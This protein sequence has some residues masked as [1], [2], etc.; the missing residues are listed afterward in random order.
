[1]NRVFA[2]TLMAYLLAIPFWSHAFVPPVET[3]HLSKADKARLEAVTCRA[4]HVVSAI[5]MKAW[6]ELDGGPTRAEVV[7]N[8]SGSYSGMPTRYAASCDRNSEEWT[9]EH[10]LQ[11]LVPT[12]A[13]VVSVTPGSVS[14]ERA[15]NTVRSLSQIEYFQTLPIRDHLKD[16]CRLHAGRAPEL[17]LVQCT[18][19]WVEVS[20]WCPA[21]DCPRIISAGY[22]S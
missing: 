8:V 19:I 18:G 17:V 9:C 14:N 10:K 22:A 2:A 11:I 6:R 3:V 15:V 16:S 4:K 20:F 7:C 5:S 12:S 13:G 21:S 1:M